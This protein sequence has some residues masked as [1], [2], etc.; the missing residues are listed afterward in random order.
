MNE[1]DKAYIAGLFDGEGC[2]LI[3]RTK[4]NTYIIECNITLTDYTPLKFIH[5]N[6]GGCLIKRKLRPNTNFIQYGWQVRSVLAKTFIAT[7]LPYSK[8]KR[9]QMEM[10]LEFRKYMEI[11]TGK[12]RNPEIA[13]M[14]YNSVKLLKR[15]KL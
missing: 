10:C 5:D 7:I 2:V 14:Y 13:N 12:L 15:N 9:K 1:I 8:I 11:N 6:F 4:T 3:K